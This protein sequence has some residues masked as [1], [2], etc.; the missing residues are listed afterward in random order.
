M[1]KL[2]GDVKNMTNDVFESGYEDIILDRLDPCIL[3]KDDAVK[4]IRHLTKCVNSYVPVGE[5]PEIMDH[6]VTYLGDRLQDEILIKIIEKLYPNYIKVNMYG[7]IHIDKKIDIFDLNRV[8]K[9]YNIKKYKV[10]TLDN[11]PI[12]SESLPYY[13]SLIIESVE[14]PRIPYTYMIKNGVEYVRC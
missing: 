10:K 7:K 6:E 12:Y 4:L 13:G 9:L 1:E 3:L 2:Y 11:I 5:L 14:E 8:A